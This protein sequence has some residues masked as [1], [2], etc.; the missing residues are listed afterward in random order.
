V[1]RA[2]LATVLALTVSLAAPAIAGAAIYV[3][4]DT[5]DTP[6]GQGCGS[7]AGCSLREAITSANA[8]PGADTIHI[9]AGTYTL[10]TPEQ[11]EVTDDL[12]IR[13]VGAGAVTIDA[14]GDSRVLGAVGA[15][16]ELLL[17]N[18]TVR[19]GAVTDTPAQGGGIRAEGPLDLQG[20]VV[21]DNS[22]TSPAGSAVGA[23][24]YAAGAATIADSSI[25]D[26][27]ALASSSAEGGGLLALGSTSLV[28]VDILDNRAQ[29]TGGAG[30]GGGVRALGSLLLS[31][32]R[33]ERNTAQSAGVSAAYGGGIS[34][35]GPS[36][37]VQQSVVR[38]NTATGPTA[39]GGGFRRN[40]GTTTEV[41]GSRVTDNLA[42]GGT[43]TGG[44]GAFVAPSATV[45]GSTF[46]NNDAVATAA[47]GGATGGGMFVEPGATV[48]MADSTVAANTV[49]ADGTGNSALGGG[50]FVGSSGTTLTGVTVS[51]N[52][53]TGNG[54]AGEVAGGGVAAAGVAQALTATGS[55]VSG[56]LQPD[57]SA[58]CANA[59]L[60]SGGGNV[61]N[62]VDGAT[63]CA[64]AAGTDDAVTGAPG[65]DPLDTYGGLTP[66]MRLT[67]SS[68]A[69]DRYSG[70]SCPAADQRGVARPQGPACDAGAFE[71]RPATVTPD[72]AAL[73]FGTHAVGATSA[74]QTLTLSNGGDLPASGLVLALG[75]AHPGDFGLSGSTCA[76]TLG[77]QSSCTVAFRFAP[78]AAGA[79]AA[80]VTGPDAPVA[81]DGTGTG[82]HAPHGGPAPVCDELGEAIAFDAHATFALR[83]SATV[84]HWQIVDAP[85]HGHLSTIDREGH[86]RYTPDRG[87][88]GFDAFRYRAVGPGGASDPA[89]ARVTVGPAPTPAA[90]PRPPV[91]VDP[92]PACSVPE[93]VG[94]KVRVARALVRERCAGARLDVTRRGKAPRRIA[95][96]T[97]AAGTPL[98]AGA[99]VTVVA[100]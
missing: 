8:D 61:V 7:F 66:T 11:L 69:L 39:Q 78:L 5:A 65:L 28:N 51:G 6:V 4:D 35:A 73:S 38:Q 55:I 82:A 27:L 47:G 12:T 43:T 63:G 24:V 83:C 84:W 95:R 53:A 54:S 16:T 60:T 20:V 18:L 79:R 46:D 62:Q 29:S 1:L 31:V 81:L 19:G 88:S 91:V 94:R 10:T 44:G 15:G 52:F 76:A 21:E 75:G 45:T 97:P 32:S 17:H 93:L 64:Y 85:Q 2:C 49:R 71:A 48:Q 77:A 87:F 70:G 57:P 30:Q 33:V 3:A 90:P 25:R 59:T 42:T 98:R 41:T 23:G 89:I 14:G 67:A 74:P 99:T 96:Q 58:D 22:V 86:V 68:P 56:N 26:N 13:R 50:L 9:L 36:F 100:R 34:A 80:T 37:A 72:T 92:A 40:G